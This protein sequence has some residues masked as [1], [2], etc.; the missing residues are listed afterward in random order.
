MADHSNIS[1][2]QATWQTV[3]GCD[4]ESPGCL[5]CYA[6][7]MAHRLEAMGHAGYQGLTK[8]TAAG[9]VVWSGVVNPAPDNLGIPLKWRKPR[10]VFVNSMS[11][12][13]HPAIPFEYIDKVFAVM[14][15]TGH[16]L[17]ISEKSTRWHTYQV[18]T[19]RT[20]RAAEYLQSRSTRRFPICG[21]HPIF[22]AG[23][24]EGGC[25]RGKGIEVMN[26]GAALSWPLPNVWIGTSAEDQPRLELRAKPLLNCPAAVRWLSLEP[27]I[28]PID[29]GKA[30]GPL[31]VDSIDWVVVGGESGP[32]ARPCSINWI[33]DIVAEC[34]AAA[35]PVFVKQLG[36]APFETM[37]AHLE[38]NRAV[39]V[40]PRLKLAD[41][42]GENP[43]EWPEDL[44]VR[45]WPRAAAI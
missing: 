11:D 13:F 33:R 32:G 31:S 23:R 28:G 44:R 35:V 27:L 41:R 9:D 5:H 36:A 16:T 6:M 1:W 26:A 7:K 20:E 25:L 4:L 30:F 3:Y 24:G 17:P 38:D 2:T 39:T 15:A 21:T 10:L 40:T 22:H 14:N 34:R 37:I 43:E 8:K 18:L 12:L 19:K 29:L 45:E 42:K